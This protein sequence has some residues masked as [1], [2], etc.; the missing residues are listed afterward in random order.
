MGRVS[1]V[2]QGND[3]PGA[4]AALDRA[5]RILAIA[6]TIAPLA[7]AAAIGAGLVAGEAL[8]PIA[9]T[10]GLL[11]TLAGAYFKMS[12]ITRAGFNQGF[13]LPHLPVRGTRT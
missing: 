4:T 7:F 1:T 11:A 13:A 12:L 5:G 6:G 2:P 3:G 10:A 8:P 9:T